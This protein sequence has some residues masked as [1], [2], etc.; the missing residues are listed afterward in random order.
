MDVVSL[1][2]GIGGFDLGFDHAGF[3]IVAHV[4]KDANCRK[5]LAAKWPNA[6]AFDD[7]CTVGKHNL[8]PCAATSASGWL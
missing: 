8:P 4:E 1:F 2:A 5:L 3:R 6:M 7:V